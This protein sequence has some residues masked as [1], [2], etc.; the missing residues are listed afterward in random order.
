M[1]ETL[2]DLMRS[3]TKLTQ[4][5]RQSQATEAIRRA[6]RGAAA[7]A[8]AARPQASA[9]VLDGCAF[10][11]DTTAPATAPPGHATFTSGTHT[12][13]GLTRGYKLFVPPARTDRPRALVMML[14]G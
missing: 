14:H 1:N 13:A 10:E 6:L 3:A 11:A 5:G 8:T 7:L 2:Q 9:L 4:A 12:H